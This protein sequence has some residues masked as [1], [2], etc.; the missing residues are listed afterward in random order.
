MSRRCHRLNPPGN[1]TTLDYTQI[2][3]NRI[4]EQTTSFARLTHV[5]L[6]YVL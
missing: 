5:T 1:P 3:H 6:S 4:A 2:S